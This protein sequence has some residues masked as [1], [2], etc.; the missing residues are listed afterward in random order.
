MV[1]GLETANLI[2]SYFSKVGH[3]LT[4]VIEP[5]DMDF[6]L[7]QIE[8]VLNWSWRVNIPEVRKLLF[9]A[10]TGKSSGIPEINP[11]LLLDCLR[12]NVDVLTDIYNK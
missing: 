9:E 2:N 10:S 4:G 7:P 1:S 3:K 6:Q 8:V 11:R 12:Y 5:A